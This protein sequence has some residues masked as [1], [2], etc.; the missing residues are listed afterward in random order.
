MKRRP[1]KCSSTNGRPIRCR[2]IDEEYIAMLT[3]A[4]VLLC[5][6]QV[7]NRDQVILRLQSDLDTSQQQYSGIIEELSIRDDEVSRLNTRAKQLQ[8]DLRDVHSQ[9]EISHERISHGEKTLGSQS[10]DYEVRVI[11]LSLPPHKSSLR[12]TF[13]SST[14]GWR[15]P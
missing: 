1:M 7:N 2:P 6:F 8:A 5:F 11:A 3:I 9:L 4:D 15:T 13:R 10:Q 14:S 12:F